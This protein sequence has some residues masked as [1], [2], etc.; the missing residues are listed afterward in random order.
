MTSVFRLGQHLVQ[1]IEEKSHLADALQGQV[2][3][4]SRQLQNIDDQL[5]QLHAAQP[6]LTSTDV[7]AWT[8]PRAEVEVQD[9]IRG[10][11]WGVVARGRF[12][13]Q[14]VAVK[15]PHP[16]IINP[17]KLERLR[18]EVGIMAHVRHPNLLR[19]IAAVFDDQT[20]PLI[21]TELLD[22]NLRTAYENDHIQNPNKLLIF[23][24]VAYA[25]HYLHGRKEPIIHGDVS[26][27][28]V[29][30]E[31]LPGGTWRAKLSD[32]GSANL[33]RLS[34]TLGE[35]GIIYTAPETFPHLDPQVRP[36]RQTTKL[37]IYSYGSLLCEVATCQFPD[38]VKY[39][40]MLQQVQTESKLIHNLIIS[41]TKHNPDERP[42]MLQ[43]LDELSKIPPKQ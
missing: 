35:G 36:P 25:L 15:S 23:Q 6:Q 22:M 5:Q 41:C 28:N 30:L 26:A 33:A 17:Q 11:A 10:E 43:V 32:C 12:R 27:P 34:R 39:N 40:D 1:A 7:R 2:Q 21:I 4:L 3:S 18:R 9:Q 42:T 14:Q 29:L 8:V 20:P 37:D 38:P 31:A 13:N 24:D 19:F 16:A